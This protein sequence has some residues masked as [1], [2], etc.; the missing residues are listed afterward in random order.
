VVATSS[1]T[2]TSE[3]FAARELVRDWASA[4]GATV[5]A[6]AI[7]QGESDAWRPVFGSLTDLGLL[8]V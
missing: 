8:V 2:G 7:E 6:R 5:A 4:S 1:K 3:Q